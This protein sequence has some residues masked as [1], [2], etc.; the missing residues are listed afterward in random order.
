MNADSKVEMNAEVL[1]GVI[2][3]YIDSPVDHKQ[4]SR[5]LFAKGK[6]S[7]L[8]DY[9]GKDYIDLVNGKG[10]I[11]LGHNDQA[12]TSAIHTF[13]EQ[14][15]EIVTGPSL[16]II[17]LA[18]RIKT[19]LALPD[20]KVSFFTTG[21]AACRAAV[22]A[23]RA[24]TGKK[25]IVSAGYHG[26][27]PMWRSSGEWLT[28]NDEGVVEFYFVP[29]LLD[30]VLTK[31]K[32][33]VALVIFSPD[34]TYLSAATI[35]K[36]IE[37]CR[38]HQVLICCDD[39]KQGYRHRQGASLE[40]VTDQKADL[41]IFSKGLS[42]GQRLSCIVGPDGIME[43][44]KE[45]TYTAYYQMLPIVSSLATLEQME[46]KSGYEK[47]N[48]YSQ[49]LIGILR[50]LIGQ[51]L[52]PIEVNGGPLF[53]FVFG[54]EKL[55]QDFYRESVE[56]GILLFEGDNQSISLSM[57]EHVQQIIAGRFAN[58]IDR[59]TDKHSHL[60]HVKVSAEQTFQAAWNMID[61][62]SDILPYAEQLKIL[63]KITGE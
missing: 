52:L 56:Q 14:N 33:Q 36:L 23:A 17:E 7:F 46:L 18:K 30:E 13:L 5:L 43:Q 42:N 61:G 16:P 27:D 9:N 22:C 35:T 59:L 12:V 47:L 39:V 4:E 60:Q 53:Q 24:A 25:I 40:L 3:T 62:A 57:D 29:Q 15:G 48:V 21:T 37:I 34:Y 50:E 10:S 38:M 11:V 20:S 45:Y 54:D 63:T 6:G 26:W 41:Y 55:E 31:Y 44:T 1:L 28:A 58:V 51:S 2:G 32:G 19:D 8:Y 49:S